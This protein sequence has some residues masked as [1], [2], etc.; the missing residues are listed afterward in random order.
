MTTIGPRINWSVKHVLLTVQV[1]FTVLISDFCNC[2]AEVPKRK[3][4]RT[5]ERNKRMK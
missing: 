3:E 5:K 4:E 1:S 2:F